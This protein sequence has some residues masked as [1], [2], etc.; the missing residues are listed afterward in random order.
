MKL[1]PSGED[2]LIQNQVQ[3]SGK[4]SLKET[5]VSLE[6][7]VLKGSGAWAGPN[8][9]GRKSEAAAMAA[10]THQHSVLMSGVL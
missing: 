10:P 2:S 3:G 9:E 6:H 1:A 5:S 7:Q 8:Q 4:S